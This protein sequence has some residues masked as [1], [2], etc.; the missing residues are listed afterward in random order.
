MGQLQSSVGGATK[1]VKIM[2]IVKKY[3]QLEK[4]QTPR[5]MLKVAKSIARAWK[6]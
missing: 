4:A 5:G 2:D 3:F 6:R 1:G